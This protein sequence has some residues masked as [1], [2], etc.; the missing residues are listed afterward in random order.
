M[1]VTI[2]HLLISNKGVK[3][4]QKGNAYQE[5]IDILNSDKCKVYLNLGSIGPALPYYGNQWEG[6]K[7][8]ILDD[9]DKP[10]GVYG[11][12]Y[13]LHSR[14]PNLFPRTFIELTWKDTRW[15]EQEWREKDHF[16]FAFAN[17]GSNFYS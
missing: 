9:S 12:A 3:V 6:L 1:P 7:Q 4:L 8:F 15:D 16:K 13:L 5:F 10:M 14:Q 11:W 2:A 17:K